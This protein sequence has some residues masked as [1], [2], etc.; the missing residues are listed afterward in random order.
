MSSGGVLVASSNQP[1][2]G[3]LVEMRIEW[4]WLLEGRIPLQLVALGRILRRGSLDF[5]AAFERHEFRILKS[6]TPPAAA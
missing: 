5:A 3:E 2:V 1:P 6:S 4:P